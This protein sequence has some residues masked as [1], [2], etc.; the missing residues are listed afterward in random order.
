MAY[1]PNPNLLNASINRDTQ[2]LAP[3]IESAGKAIAGGIEQ[4]ASMRSA[5]KATDAEFEMFQQMYPDAA[6]MIDGEKFAAAN[7]QGKQ[8]MLGLAKGYVMEQKE[9]ELLDEKRRLMQEEAAKR[10]QLQTITTKDGGTL[11]MTGDG[12]MVY[13]NRPEPVEKTPGAPTMADLGGGYRAVLQ[14][15]RIARVIEPSAA[16]INGG[17][18]GRYVGVGGSDYKI[19]VDA[20]GN[21]ITGLPA[22]QTQRGPFAGGLSRDVPVDPSVAAPREYAPRIVEQDG[23]KYRLG[24]DGVTL[25]PLQVQGA[26]AAAAPAPAGSNFLNWKPIP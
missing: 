16:D 12:R 24:A 1:N 13:S 3:G 17:M 14:D 19:P 25:I 5:A 18:G 23:V 20:N 9:S 4:Y 11:V 10:S 15:G 21:R 6:A 2:G 7:L 8:K 26:P 22:M